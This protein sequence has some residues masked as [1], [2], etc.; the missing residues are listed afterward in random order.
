MPKNEVDKHENSPLLTTLVANYAAKSSPL[1]KFLDIYLLFCIANGVLQA[2]YYLM[3]GSFQYNAFLGGFISSVG[4]FV[5]AGKHND[6]LNKGLKITSANIRLKES[7]AAKGNK[8]LP[9]HLIAEFILG[10]VV[11]NLFIANFI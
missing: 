10:T 4:S 9:E 1:A 11:L 5:L 6:T 7:I 2:V 8:P 3:A